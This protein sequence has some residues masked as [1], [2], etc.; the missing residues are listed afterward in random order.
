MAAGVTPL[1]LLSATM[2]EELHRLSGMVARQVAD[3][4][5][6]RV[7]A[8]VRPG[9][10]SRR[11]FDPPPEVPGQAVPGPPSRPAQRTFTPK[12]SKNLLPK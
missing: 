7:E 6:A 5:L 9:P 8:L 3:G 10:E 11:N 4:V 2:D 1:V 12:M